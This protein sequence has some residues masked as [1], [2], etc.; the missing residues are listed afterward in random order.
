MKKA[1]WIGTL[2]TILLAAGIV[3]WVV[4]PKQGSGRA[5]QE[6]SFMAIHFIDVGQ[7]GGI[8][9]QK[10]DLRIL[11]DCGDTFAGPIVTNYLSAR[12]V[13]QID[14]MIISHAHEDH[15]AGCIHVLD[16]MRVGT[17][18]HNGSDAQTAVWK[19]FLAEAQK[20][21][22]VIAVDKDF[23]LDG[24]EFFVGYD[25]RGKHFSLEADNSLV[26]RITA[27]DVRALFTGDCEEACEK[28]ISKTSDVRAQ[29]LSVGHHGSNASSTTEFL[30]K[31]MPQFAVIQA[32]IGNSYGHPRPEALER[33]QAVGAQ[34]YRT[35]T[36]GS[37]VVRIDGKTIEV[38][39][40]H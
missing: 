18:Y 8:F 10:G 33:L 30:K 19:K 34:I 11:Y 20:T 27:G 24:L 6:S 16:T 40:Q 17:V 15:M 26:A 36:S 28:E 38:E 14:M 5:G 39:T 35:D 23:S 31:V 37:I 1:V 32:G 7:G 4:Q 3:W 13:T 29:I 22:A 25:S 9:I 2:F 21:D 12:G